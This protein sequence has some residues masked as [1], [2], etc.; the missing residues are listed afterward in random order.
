M[1]LQQSSFC[2]TPSSLFSHS[3]KQRNQLRLHQQLGSFRFP[4]KVK[5]STFIVS[6]SLGAGFFNDIAQIAQNKVTPFPFCC[7]ICWIDFCILI[8]CILL[9]RFWLQLEF[10]WQLGNFLSHLLLCFCMAKSLMSRL[11]FKR[12]VS[13]HHTLLY[14][15]QILHFTDTINTT[16]H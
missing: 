8:C 16:R 15:L 12:E 1:S 3:L 6:S 2:V 10:L 9:L 5:A 7:F 14:V 4:R 13:L 11:L